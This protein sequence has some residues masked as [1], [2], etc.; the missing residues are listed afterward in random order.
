MTDV[1]RSVLLHIG[2][3]KCGSTSIQAALFDAGAELSKEGV[4]YHAEKRVGGQAPLA[5]LIGVTA[6]A[7]NMERLRA[8]SRETLRE[9]GRRATEHDAAILSG[10]KFIRANPGDFIG[11]L[12]EVF[13]E[14]ETI[15]VLAYVRD[16]LSMYLSVEQQRLKASAWFAPPTQVRDMSK[17]LSRWRR[18]PRVNRMEV[19]AFDPQRFPEGSVVRDFETVLQGW[20]P[21]LK[22]RLPDIRENASVTAEQLV[23]LQRFRAK[24]F[25]EV[26]TFGRETEGLLLFFHDLNRGGS[27]LNKPTLSQDAADVLTV[28]STDMVRRL[29]ATYPSLDLPVRTPESTPVERSWDRIE[30][31]LETVDWPV[32]DALIALIP[33]WTPALSDGPTEEAR[34]ALS[35]LS[36]LQPENPGHA[37]AATG[38]YWRNSGLVKGADALDLLEI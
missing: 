18:S 33:K 36:D 13:P 21:G 26:T 32:V 15:T 30:D 4:L 16:P 25:P 24:F 12:G 3:G 34:S 27:L 35:L 7:E 10:E 14:L 2:D 38:R 17:A 37:A 22:T 5:T 31:V 6:R 28:C 19:R 23:L 11:M 29:N 20:R 8:R 1:V 9:I